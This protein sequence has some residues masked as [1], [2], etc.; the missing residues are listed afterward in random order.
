MPLLRAFLLLFAFALPSAAQELPKPI[1]PYVN[2]NIGLLDEA[3]VSLLEGKLRDLREARGIEMTVVILSRRA[4]YGTDASMEAFATRLFN[5]WGIGDKTRND[6]ILFLVLK[7]DRQTRIEL[8]R[9]Y[10]SDYDG[11]AARILD[12]DVLPFFK[13]G[14]F[15]EGISRGTGEIIDE[16]ALR[17]ADGL[18]APVQRRDWGS[19]ILRIV[20]IGV[21]ALVFIPLFFGRF[22]RDRATQLS[23][24]PSCG[25]RTLSVERETLETA[26]KG[27]KGRKSRRVY[28]RNC[29]HSDTHVWA[30]AAASSS[31]S[32]SSSSF[33]GGSSGG[34]GASGSW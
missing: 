22:L 27:K 32:S 34:G 5:A 20:I 12:R 15:A 11:T 28:C 10:G 14:E 2:D 4:A 24:C 21:A 6:G 26:R 30:Y 18:G 16:I 9:A 7:D 3:D 31:T 13:N 17:H 19:L 33:G 23:R 25:Q 29:D 8:G 1:S